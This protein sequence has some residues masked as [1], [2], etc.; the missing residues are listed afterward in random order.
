MPTGCDGAGLAIG[1]V[2][3]FAK[4]VP[5]YV[6]GGTDTADVITVRAPITNMASNRRLPVLSGPTCAGGRNWFA[7]RRPL[8]GCAPRRATPDPAHHRHLPAHG[9]APAQLS[10]RYPRGSS[11]G[12]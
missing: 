2:H 3:A 4:T 1:D 6:G 5:A 12:A 8:D 11:A 10:V 7:R 9:V